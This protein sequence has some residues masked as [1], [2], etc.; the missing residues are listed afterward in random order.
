MSG[1]HLSALMTGEREGGDVSRD[2]VITIRLSGGHRVIWVA[3]MLGLRRC[4]SSSFQKTQCC[5]MLQI[6]HLCLSR[7]V[8]KG[9]S[10]PLTRG[11]GSL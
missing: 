11:A 4:G 7:L 5:V 2:Y 1:R 10:L 9:S 8:L 3:R 6:T